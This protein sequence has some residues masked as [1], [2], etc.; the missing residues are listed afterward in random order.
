MEENFTQIAPF[1]GA[2]VDPEKWRFVQ[3]VS[4][5]FLRDRGTLFDGRI[6]AGRIRDG[7]G[8]LRTEHVYFYRGIQIIDCI[9]FNDRFRYGD[10]VADIA[11]LYMDLARQGLPTWGQGFLGAYVA[12]SGDRQAYALV[13]FYAVYRAVVRLKIACFQWADAATDSAAGLLE[14]DIRL[15]LDQA[16][17]YAL[18]FGRPTLWITCGLPA[19]G[20]SAQADGVSD[21]LKIE[22]IRSD[23]VRREMFDSPDATVVP[24]GRRRYRPGMRGGATPAC[25]PWPR[26]GFGPGHRCCWTPPF[27]FENGVRRHGCW[28]AT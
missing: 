22:V 8:D 16:Y 17:G 28:P 4:R 7:H 9:K 27:P 11:F 19:S 24:F 2:G 15:Y 10:A 21:A 13:D 18:A 14:N 25:W 26:S 20:K 12:A 3:E 6:A 23:A 1:V 5:A